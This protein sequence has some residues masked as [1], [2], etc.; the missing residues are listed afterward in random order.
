MAIDDL[1]LSILDARLIPA[2]IT[3]HEIGHLMQA[4]ADAA[5]GALF[6]W[7]GARYKVISSRLDK[8]ASDRFFE[9]EFIW[10]FTA[11]G[12]PSGNAVQTI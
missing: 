12:R 9:P 4:T 7:I 3:G 1:L 10:K 8:I 6:D 5:T 2:F 11:E